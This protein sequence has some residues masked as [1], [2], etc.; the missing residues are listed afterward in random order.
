VELKMKYKKV[1]TCYE[2]GG[3]GGGGDDDNDDDRKSDRNINM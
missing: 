1:Y 3:G 2:D